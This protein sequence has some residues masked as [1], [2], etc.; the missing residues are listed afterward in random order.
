MT[1]DLALG[2]RQLDAEPAGD[3]VAH[4]GIAVFDVVAAGRAGLP[5]LVQLARQAAGGADHDVVARRRRGCTAPITCASDGS[6]ALAGGGDARRPRRSSVGHRL[7]ARLAQAAGARQ[8]P[9]AVVER[10][11]A[12]L[13]SRDQRQRAVLAG[14][15]GLRR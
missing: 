10:L 2:L 6:S 7:R 15:E 1:N 12:A 14:V 13:A 9:S 3:L 4:A 5:Q 11:Q 8:S